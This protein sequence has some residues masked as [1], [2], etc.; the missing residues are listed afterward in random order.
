MMRKPRK[1]NPDPLKA[2]FDAQVQGIYESQVRE[3]LGLPYNAPFTDKKGRRIDT[4][5]SQK[6]RRELLSGAFAIA[7]SVGRRHGY[8]VSSP[9]RYIPFPVIPTA[10]GLR[11]SAERMADKKEHRADVGR[12][13]KSLALARKR[14]KK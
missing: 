3:Q 10:K 14:K 8:L 11:R 1:A 9:D 5:L 12:F 2:Q 6:V 13:E 4:K 7:T